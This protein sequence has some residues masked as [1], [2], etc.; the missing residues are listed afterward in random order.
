MR[1]S[2]IKKI[3]GRI[4]ELSLEDLAWD[5]YL[6]NNDIL[7]AVEGHLMNYG[8]KREVVFDDEEA[9]VLIIVSDIVYTKYLFKKEDRYLEYNVQENC[10]K[11]VGQINDENIKERDEC[12]YFLLGKVETMYSEIALKEIKEHGRE[13]KE[14]KLQG[15][16]A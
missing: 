12:I 7:M 13:N 6:N 10:A 1:I 14:K 15:C 3:F 16:N 9:I 2:S 11:I 8:W 5:T 4:Q